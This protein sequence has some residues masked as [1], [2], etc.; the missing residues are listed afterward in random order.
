M[1]SGYLATLDGWRAIAIAGVLLDHATGTLR[2]A[3][4]YTFMRTGPNG[5]SVF[6]AVSGFLICT[7]LLEEEQLTGKFKLKGFYV[8]RA[9]RILPAAF[10]YLAIIGVLGIL[11]ILTVTPLEWASCVL[12]SGTTSR[13]TGYIMA[14]E[15]QMPVI[16][17][18][19][20]T[21]AL[22]LGSDRSRG[23]CLEMICADF[24]AGANLDH[25]D[26]EMLLFSMTRFFRF[27]PEEQRQAF[28]EGLSEKAS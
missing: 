7:R 10:C 15:S 2:Q 19:I 11:G 16:E 1:R 12:F 18:A 20:E 27:L 26:P 4:E 21:A 14:G 8:R 3:R 17:K 25:G 28:L 6:F 5:V 13:Q 24:L 22:M 9:C 23:Y